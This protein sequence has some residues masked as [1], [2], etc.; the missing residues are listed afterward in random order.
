MKYHVYFI[1]NDQTSSNFTLLVGVN[2][3]ISIRAKVSDA[4]YIEGLPF[5]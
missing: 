4:M 3:V 2:F 5:D 1:I